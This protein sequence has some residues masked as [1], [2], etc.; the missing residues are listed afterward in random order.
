M[1]FW[2]IVWF[3][4]LS[5]ALI[6]Y[7]MLLFSILGDLFRDKETSGV[8]KAAWIFFFLFLP[9][10]TALFYVVRRGEAMA[11]RNLRRM[12]AAKADQDRY[13]RDVAKQASPAAQIAQAKALL[14]SGDITADEYASIRARALA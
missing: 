8:T 11:E 14:D 5:Y 9:I 1:S 12:E 13:I 6:A 7:L 4:I 2:D 10:V 3:I